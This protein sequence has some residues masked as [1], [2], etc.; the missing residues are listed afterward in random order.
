MGE[1][2]KIAE[3]SDFD[4]EKSRIV[5]EVK[6]REIGIFHL[7]GEY[8]GVLNYCVHQAGPLCEGWLTGEMVIGD[9]GWEWDLE[10]ENQI[11]T[12]PWH[13]WKF[14]IKTGENIDDSKY[15]VPVYEIVEDDGDLFIES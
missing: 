8:F 9:D 4:G 7:D 2:T 11:I 1:R 5:A 14:D 10:K 15:S 6:G 3:V 12:C 13:R